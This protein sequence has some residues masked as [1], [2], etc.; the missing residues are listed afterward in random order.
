[1]NSPKG[2]TEVAAAVE[3]VSKIA[4]ENKHGAEEFVGVT[5]QLSDESH[6][7]EEIVSRFQI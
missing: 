3:V 4:D 6:S 2:T 7:L 5:E 1:M